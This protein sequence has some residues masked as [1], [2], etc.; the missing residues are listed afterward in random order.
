MPQVRLCILSGL[1]DK[2]QGPNGEERR[3][4]ADNPTVAYS[5]MRRAR[6]RMLGKRV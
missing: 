5:V 6:N 1:N 4:A 3:H 2:R